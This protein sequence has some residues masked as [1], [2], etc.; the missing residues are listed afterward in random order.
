MS[1]SLDSKRVIDQTQFCPFS[2]SDASSYKTPL[3]L[4]LGYPGKSP[5]ESAHTNRKAAKARGRGLHLR[6][7]R[8]F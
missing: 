3:L 8:G 2:I 6:A 5:D 1:Q 7:N 4:Q